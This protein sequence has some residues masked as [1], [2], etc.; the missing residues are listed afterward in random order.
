[1]SQ[2]RLRENVFSFSLFYC[3]IFMETLA[4]IRQFLYNR[5]HRKENHV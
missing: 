1:M 2:R 3:R 5:K 4:V